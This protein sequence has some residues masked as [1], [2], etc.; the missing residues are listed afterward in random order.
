M[1]MF[2]KSL[3]LELGP[4]KVSNTNCHKQKK[5]LAEEMFKLKRKQ[6]VDKGNV[7]F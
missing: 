5:K 4:H 2:T 3:A 6:Q 7:N 1:D